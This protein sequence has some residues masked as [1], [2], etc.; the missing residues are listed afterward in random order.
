[1]LLHGKD[2]W[3]VVQMCIDRYFATAALYKRNTGG[4]TQ[5]DGEQAI[6]HRKV[7]ATIIEQLKGIRVQLRLSAKGKGKGTG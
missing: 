6:H 7:A 1:M 4:S 5:R 3:D 2:L